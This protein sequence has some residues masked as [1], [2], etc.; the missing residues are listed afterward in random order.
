[1]TSARILYTHNI[2]S[3]KYHIIE[4]R[5]LRRLGNIKIEINLFKSFLLFN[6]FRE[7]F[8]FGKK[9]LIEAKIYFTLN[10]H[11]VSFV[12]INQVIPATFKIG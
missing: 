8:M 11:C 7:I 1:M 6:F 2:L 10:E 9:C 4:Q 5:T 12:E 3:L